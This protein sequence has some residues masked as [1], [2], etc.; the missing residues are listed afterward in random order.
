MPAL[1]AAR[2]CSP[3]NKVPGAWGPAGR[4]AYGPWAGDRSRTSRLKSACSS[5]LLSGWFLPLLLACLGRRPRP[6]ARH[7][8]SRGPPPQLPPP[9]AK[10]VE[11]S[12]DSPASLRR[13]HR[14]RRCC[15]VCQPRQGRHDRRVIGAAELGHPH[16]PSD[17][18][19]DRGDRGRGP[20]RQ[21]RTSDWTSRPAAGNTTH[22]QRPAHQGRLC[23]QVRVPIQRAGTHASHRITDLPPAVGVGLGC[24]S[25]LA[26]PDFGG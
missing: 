23:H 10:V 7:E 12:R 19:R 8:S 2:R 1:I 9:H 6:T 20:G 5:W 25:A 15:G 21:S 3:T 13:G 17:R 4:V 26:A 14:D 11:S 24:E 16:A 22:G 18:P